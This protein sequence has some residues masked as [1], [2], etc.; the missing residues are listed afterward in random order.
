MRGGMQRIERCE[1]P[2]PAFG[3]VLVSAAAFEMALLLC[4]HA[5]KSHAAF[6]SWPE[7]GIAVAPADSAQI[8]P[9]MVPDQAGGVIIVW[10]DKRGG[11]FLAYA[12]H[13]IVNGLSAAGWPSA[14]V[15]LPN[16]G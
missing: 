16:R 1:M 12:Q 7:N 6:V 4:T 9:R 11:P 5:S 8:T 14:G 3:S 10:E 2:R 13:L 15:L